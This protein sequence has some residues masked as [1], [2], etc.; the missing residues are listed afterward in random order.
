MSIAMELVET[1]ASAAERSG[2]RRVNRVRVRVGAFSG[3]VS[4]ALDFAFDVAASDTLLDGATLEI[5]EVP[6]VIFCAAC[7][8]E[9]KPGRLDGLV[10]PD[11]GTI[12][13]TIRAGRELELVD[14]EVEDS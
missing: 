12:S 14:I 1:A 7:G 2:A 9:K 13:D 10:C 3:V 8:D 6:L 5:E 11:C 4:D